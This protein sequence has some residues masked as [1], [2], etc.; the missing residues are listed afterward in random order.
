[1]T[2]ELFTEAFEETMKNDVITQGNRKSSLLQLKGLS[3]CVSEC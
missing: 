3:S 1:M 2:K